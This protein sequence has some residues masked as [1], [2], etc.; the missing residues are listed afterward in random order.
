MN[1]AV[2]KTC[3]SCEHSTPS[4]VE[5]MTGFVW[6]T[7]RQKVGGCMEA[8]F[9][10]PD[11]KRECAAFSA[12]ANAR[13]LTEAVPASDEDSLLPSTGALTTSIPLAI[14]SVRVSVQPTQPTRPLTK[15]TQTPDLFADL[16]M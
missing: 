16:F 5:N 7:K 1:E 8:V 9:H 6:C 11:W 10:N 14:P 4:T 12:V 3:G 15:K 2:V 13:R